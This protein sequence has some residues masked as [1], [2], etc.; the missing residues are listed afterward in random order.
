MEL[1]Q[2]HK[3]HKENSDLQLAF[4]PTAF[5]LEYLNRAIVQQELLSFLEVP[6][7]Y[8]TLFPPTATSSRCSDRTRTNNTLPNNCNDGGFGGGSGGGSNKRGDGKRNSR[9]QGV[10]LN[11]TKSE[12]LDKDKGIFILDRLPYFKSVKNPDGIN[13]PPKVTVDIVQL[14][15][16]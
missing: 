15:T 2:G 11:Q 13:H 1:R 4:H 14:Y 6:Q 5:F 12:S 10:D 16:R 7:L 3:G 9:S 8:P